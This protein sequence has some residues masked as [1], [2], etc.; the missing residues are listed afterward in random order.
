MGAPNS[1]GHDI[2]LLALTVFCWDFESICWVHAEK[3]P[4]RLDVQLRIDVGFSAL[5]GRRCV[6]APE[7][8]PT[9]VL[10]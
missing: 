4:D 10:T 5:K 3:V 8:T 1:R 2:L 7:A 9:C 6:N